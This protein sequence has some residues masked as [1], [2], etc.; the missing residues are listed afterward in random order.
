MSAHLGRVLGGESPPFVADQFIALVA[1]I[2]AQDEPCCDFATHILPPS[3]YTLT[4][5]PEGGTIRLL[6]RLFHLVGKLI[7]QNAP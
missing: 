3:G 6:G 1:A 7:Y 2:L 4:S 5:L